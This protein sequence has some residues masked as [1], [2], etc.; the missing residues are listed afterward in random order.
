[1]TI[2][3]ILAGLVL[4]LIFLGI[5]CVAFAERAKPTEEDGVTPEAP[6]LPPNWKPAKPIKRQRYARTPDRILRGIH[7]REQARHE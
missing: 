7:E 4:A 3:H 1:M 6:F 5:V 2:P